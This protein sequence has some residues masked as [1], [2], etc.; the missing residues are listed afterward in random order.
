MAPEERRPETAGEH[1]LSLKKREELRLTGVHNV[2]SFDDQEI[3]LETNSGGLIIRGEDLHISQLN[4]EAGNLA[5]H[6]FVEVLQYTG[7][8]LSKKGRGL[9]GKMFK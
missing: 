7:D 9:F 6:G 5:V 3:V 4:L 2:E 8:S 1:Q